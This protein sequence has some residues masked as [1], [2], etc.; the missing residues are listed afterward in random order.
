V[1]KKLFD[2]IFDE[3]IYTIIHELDKNN[4]MIKIKDLNN[5]KIEI[6]KEYQDLNRQYKEHVFSKTEQCLLDRHKVASCICGAFLRVSVLDKSK[7]VDQIKKEK[8][9]VEAIFYYVN[10]FVAFYAGCRYLSFFM[11]CDKSDNIL[12]VKDILKEFPRMPQTSKS[13]KGFWNCVLFNLSQIKD[14]TQIGLAHYDLYVYA[15]LFF[16]LEEFF[17]EKETIKELQ[18]C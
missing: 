2:K 1:D 8:Q 14:E 11:A 13:K 12:L 4:A 7:L 16:Y 10:E 6:F 5:C 17:Y 9:P 15:M 18:K 3:E